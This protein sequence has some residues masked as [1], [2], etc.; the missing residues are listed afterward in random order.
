MMENGIPTQYKGKSLSEIEIDINEYIDE[1][2]LGKLFT[3]IDKN[4]SRH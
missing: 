4:C 2:R 3:W 1:N